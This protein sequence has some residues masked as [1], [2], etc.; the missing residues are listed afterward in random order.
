MVSEP[1]ADSRNKPG[2]GVACVWVRD[3]LQTEKVERAGLRRGELV[4]IR[5]PVPNCAVG[6]DAGCLHFNG[7]VDGCE[8]VAIAGRAK[9]P[10]KDIRKWRPPVN[11]PELTE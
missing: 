7:G 9:P 6:L 11:K 10:V 4:E 2:K 5:D 3:C 1:A 8:V